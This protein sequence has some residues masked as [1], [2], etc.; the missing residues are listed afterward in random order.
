MKT[1][2]TANEGKTEKT[3]I[4]FF[5]RHLFEPSNKQRKIATDQ[6]AEAISFSWKVSKRVEEIKKK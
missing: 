6:L 1:S 5:Y 2:E 3:E 4:K